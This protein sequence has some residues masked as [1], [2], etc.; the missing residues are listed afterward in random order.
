[1]SA[2]PQRGLVGSARALE[3]CGKRWRLRLI[4]PPEGAGACAS[5]G[6]WLRGQLFSKRAPEAWGLCGRGSS[7]AAGLA[8]PEG[9]GCDAHGPTGECPDERVTEDAHAIGYAPMRRGDELAWQQ[10]GGCAYFGR[11]GSDWG[12]CMSERSPLDGRATFEHHSCEAYVPNAL[13]W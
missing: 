10:C 11:M 7:P 8:T 5:C 13:G 2:E 4:A 9:H 6:A 12:A 1:V 3:R